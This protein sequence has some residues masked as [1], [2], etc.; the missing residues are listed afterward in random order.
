[1][2]WER[3]GTKT[4]RRKWGWIGRDEEEGWRVTGGRRDETGG[5]KTGEI[6]AGGARETDISREITRA[7]WES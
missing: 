5:T 4:R 2:E 1:M 3:E 6:R 7:E